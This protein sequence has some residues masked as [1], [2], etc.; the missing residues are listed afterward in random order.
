MKELEN[1]FF[2]DEASFRT[3]LAANHDKCPGIWMVYNKKH[4]GKECITYPEALDTALCYGWIDSIIKKID[5]TRYA[6]KFMPRTNTKKWSEFN[7]KRV[8]VLIS[9]GRMTETGLRKIES[10]LKT[11][12]IS[13][14]GSNAAA[15]TKERLHCPDYILEAFAGNEPAL[16]NFNNLAPSYQRHYILWITSAKREITQRNRIEEAIGLLRKNKKLGLK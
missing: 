7:K 2:A 5:D 14:A 16:S 8:A 3:W 15:T 6:R 12:K 10:Y 1:K 4:T 13:W 9:E 11:G